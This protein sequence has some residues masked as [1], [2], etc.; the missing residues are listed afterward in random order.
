MVSHITVA[1]MTAT[2]S[3]R[4]RRPDVVVVNTIRESGL[5][6][7]VARVLMMGQRTIFVAVETVLLARSLA[8]FVLRGH[9]VRIIPR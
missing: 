5:V 4:Q 7:A 3:G 9:I 2:L 1:V 6:L 8:G